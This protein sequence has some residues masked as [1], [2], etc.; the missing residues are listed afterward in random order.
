MIAAVLDLDVSACSRAEAADHVARGF[1]DAHDVVD[2][3]TLEPVD[4]ERA[5]GLGLDLLTVADDVVD[6]GHF[7]EA[8]GL[9]LCGTAGDDNACCGMLAAQLA[10]CLRR[11]AHGLARDG[12]GIDDDAVLDAGVACM[13][14][15][16]LGLVDIEAAAEGYDKRFRHCFRGACD[17]GRNAMCMTPSRD[18]QRA[19]RLSGRRA[20]NPLIA[21]NQAIR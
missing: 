18:G 14:A 20:G 8:L 7:R 13:L 2:D 17:Y 4:R 19:D 1:L 15:H 16:H 9:D 3:H 21:D 12:A 5:E 11:L 6:L 10:D